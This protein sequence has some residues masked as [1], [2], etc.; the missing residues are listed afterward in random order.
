TYAKLKGKKAS[1]KK[2][3]TSLPS[4]DYKAV[5]PYHKGSGV[6]KVQKAL[7]SVYYYP[8]KGAKY[9]G[10][11]GVYGTDTADAVKR[12]QSTHGLQADGVYTP[13][14]QTTLEKNKK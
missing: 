6:R 10:V 4:T 14:T 13:K 11:D 8:N 12:Y 1:S 2:T 7:A 9:I 5:K 3:K